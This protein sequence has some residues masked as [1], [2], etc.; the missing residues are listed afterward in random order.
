MLF[1]PQIEQVMNT[2]YRTFA[3]TSCLEGGTSQACHVLS[4]KMSLF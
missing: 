3:V 1:M 4:L 2:F